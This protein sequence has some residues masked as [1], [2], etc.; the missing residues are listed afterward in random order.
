MK[1]SIVMPTFNRG[2]IVAD[3]IKSVLGQRYPDFEL[4]VVDDGSVDDTPQ[5]MEKFDDRRIKYIRHERNRGCS[6]AY[7]TGI[8]AASGE[9]IAF[10]DSDD[11][12]QPDYLA[13][14]VDFLSKNPQVDAVFCDTEIVGRDSSSRLMSHMNVF[15]KLL[16][17]A[18]PTSE[19]TFSPRQIYL[20]LL[21]EVPIKPT[22]V[23]IR[24]DAL[25]QAGLFDEDW[26]SGTDWD[27]F[28][29]LARVAKGFGYIDVPLAAQRRTADATHQL[30]RDKDKLFLIKQFTLAK[31]K[32]LQD[33]DREAISAVNTG[34]SSHYNSLAWAYLESNL[35]RTA[36]M[37]YATGF[38]ETLHLQLLKKLLFALVRISIKRVKPRAASTRVAA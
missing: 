31:G 11:L 19:Y 3:A 30:F 4:L 6:A 1:V 5:I 24:T 8:I 27:L 2:Y 15:P 9:A 17:P 34:L 7:N 32:A 13:R 12:W 36:L 26:P 38:R 20:C 33:N 16:S 22:A 23:V 28:L 21:N 18:S 29:R 25:R 37:T 35:D 14:Q 10:L